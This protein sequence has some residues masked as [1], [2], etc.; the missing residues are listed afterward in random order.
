M[1]EKGASALVK[2]VVIDSFK[3]LADTGLTPSQY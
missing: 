1:D 3:K 2:E